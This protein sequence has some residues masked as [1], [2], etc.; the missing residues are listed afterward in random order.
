MHRPGWNHWVAF[1]SAFLTFLPRSCP[2][3]ISIFFSL[4]SPACPLPTSCPFNPLFPFLLQLIFSSGPFIPFFSPCHQLLLLIYFPFVY[5]LFYFFPSLIFASLFV[6]W[7]ESQLQTMFYLIMMILDPY[8]PEKILNF[9]TIKRELWEYL[10]FT[11]CK[12]EKW[13]VC[14]WDMSNREK[15]CAPSPKCS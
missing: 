15:S 6:K 7:S 8:E 12:E 5:L 1:F 2:T 14:H 11:F 9:R 13:G 3:L 4:L 10:F